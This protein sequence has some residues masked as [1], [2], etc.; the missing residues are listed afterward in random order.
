MKHHC[1]TGKC[2][3][4]AHHVLRDGNDR[5]YC[6]YCNK[7]LCRDQLAERWLEMFDKK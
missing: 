1:K 4:K 5:F 2:W 3:G 7:E 6:A